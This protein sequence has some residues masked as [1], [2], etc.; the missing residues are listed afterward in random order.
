[1]HC[2]VVPEPFGQVVIEGMAAGVSVVAAGAGGPAEIVT[3]GVDGILTP[4]GDARELARVLRVLHDD[5]PL[6]A[7]LAEAGRRRSRDFTPERSARG[8]ASV[9]AAALAR[10]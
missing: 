1:V 4:P 3:S 2:S 7:R 9:Y 10:R 5:P 6:R 8:V